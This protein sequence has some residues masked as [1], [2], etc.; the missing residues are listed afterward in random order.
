MLL[1]INGIGKQRI[2]YK[3]HKDIE[4]DSLSSY[5]LLAKKAISKFANSVFSGLS[6]K[7][8]NDE[9]AVSSIATAIMMADWR[10]DDNYKNQQGT[11]KSKYSYRNQCAIWA[12]QTYV[13]KTY[14]KPKNLGRVYSLDHNSD[15]IDANNIHDCI[16]DISSDSPDDILMEK[17]RKESVT[18]LVNK[19]FDLDILSDRQKDYIRMYYLDGYTFEKIGIKYG[20][21]REAARQGL[22]KAMNII[23]DIVNDKEII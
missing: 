9:D 7:M 22:N 20:V 6:K 13:S 5:I 8:L 3:D 4:F 1:K 21:T 16:E 12:I 17:E 14:K 11:K 23:R 18:N 19:L 10:W 2:S 15:D